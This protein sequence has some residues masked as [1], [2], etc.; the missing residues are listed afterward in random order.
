M[1]DRM[2]QVQADMIAPLINR[3]V[4]IIKREALKSAINGTSK[5]RMNYAKERAFA[6]YLFALDCYGTAVWSADKVAAR[7]LSIY[8]RLERI[9]ANDA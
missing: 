7:T 5:D 4:K 3:T 2:Q 1:T 8:F 9:A 6:P